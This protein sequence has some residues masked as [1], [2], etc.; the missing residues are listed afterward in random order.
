MRPSLWVLAKATLY[1][2]IF[3]SICFLITSYQNFPLVINLFVYVF[4]CSVFPMSLLLVI[5][6]RKTE[7]CQPCLCPLSLNQ[8]LSRTGSQQTFVEWASELKSPLDQK[9]CLWL[10][11]LSSTLEVL[12][13]YCFIGFVVQWLNVAMWIPLFTSPNCLL[14]LKIKQFHRSPEISRSLSI[15]IKRGSLYF[16]IL[17]TFW[18]QVQ[19]PLR[20]IP[21]GPCLHVDRFHG[22]F[23]PP[24]RKNGNF[25][26]PHRPASY[27]LGQVPGDREREL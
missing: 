15:V 13:R 17:S 21:P 22:I 2:S 14:P 16:L 20:E 10:P 25:R 27:F 3:P 11:C 1:P 24:G 5:S 7:Y 12:Y 23:I 18:Y 8:F 4:P 6:S 19:A 26:E 9:L